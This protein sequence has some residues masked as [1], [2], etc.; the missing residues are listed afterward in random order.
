MNVEQ[1]RKRER[2]KKSVV[3]VDGMSFHIMQVNN[4]VC[5]ND[6]LCS[7]WGKRNGNRKDRQKTSEEKCVKKV[8]QE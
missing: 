3:L 1:A 6:E 4:E 8:C 2:K 7:L 5:L